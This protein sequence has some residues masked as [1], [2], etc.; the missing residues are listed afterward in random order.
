MIRPNTPTDTPVQI[1]ALR[2]KKNKFGGVV[3]RP[4]T[5]T[6][7]PVQN[8]AVPLSNAPVQPL[9]TLKERDA[10]IARTPLMSAVLGVLSWPLALI[11]PT[12]GKNAN[13]A[14]NARI[15]ETLK[16]RVDTLKAA[17][18]SPRKI[19]VVAVIAIMVI[20]LGYFA[21]R[22]YGTRLGAKL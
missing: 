20:G 9:V 17:L 11:N 8:T 19:F 14:N 15:S 18:P 3:I 6:E 5:P 1:T 22:T 12:L 7:T 2:F 13:L 4:N 16:T 21:I 10:A